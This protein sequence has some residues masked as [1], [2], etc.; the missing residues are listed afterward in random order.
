[1]E[2]ALAGSSVRAQAQRRQLA[3]SDH[4]RQVLLSPK[5]DKLLGTNQTAAVTAK[6]LFLV[7]VTTNTI[8][9]VLRLALK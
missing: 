1:M 4:D 2:D 5:I 8:R 9:F 3:R 6:P 7:S